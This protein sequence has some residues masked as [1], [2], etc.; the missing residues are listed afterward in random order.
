MPSELFGSLP[1]GTGALLSLLVFLSFG[2]IGAPLVV[3][4]AAT[5]AL[6][7]L[8]GASAA[9][10]IIIGV[11]LLFL[12]LP[13]LRQQLLT[14]SIVAALRKLNILPEISETEQIALQAGTTWVDK[15]LFSGKP[16]L[17]RII[18]KE[19]YV[20][21]SGEELAFVNGPVEELCRMVSDWQIWQDKDLPKAVWDYIKKERFLGMIIPK[22]YGGLGFSAMAHSEVIAKIGSRSMPAAV[23]VMVPNSLG[24]AELLTHYG[25]DK[26]KNHYLPRL[27]RGEEIPCFALT[28]PNAG[29]D[30]GSMVST[31]EV[32]KGDD[33]QI[34]VRLNWRKRYITLAAIST[35]IGLAVR[36]R[37]P[38]NLLGK[39]E[40]LGITCLLVPSTTKGV[41]LGKRHDPMGVPFFNCPTEGHDVVVSIDQIIGGA[42]GAGHGWKMLMECL[43]AG[44]SISL[45]AQSTGGSK[46]A[47]R[48]VSAYGTIRRQFGISIA[49]FEGIEEPLAR[50]YGFTY[51]MEAMRIFTAG[52]VDQGMKPSVVSAIAKYNATELSRKVINDA[53]DVLGGAAISRGPRNT[54]ANGYIATPIGITVEGANILTRSMIIFGQGAIRCHPYA[55]AEV[56]ALGEN[57]IKGFD[58]AFW[59]HVGFVIRNTCRAILLSVTRG[60]LAAV[61]G[62]PLAPYYRKLA[63]SSATFSVLADIAL[64]GLGGSLKFREKITGRFADILSWMYLATST[65]KRF[66]TEGR[67]K[68]HQIFAEWALQYCFARM[69]DAYDG[70]FANFDIPVLSKFFAGPVQ[71]WSRL[72]RL[73]QDPSDKLG[74][75]LVT[76]MDRPSQVRDD[77]TEG[78]FISKDLNDAIGRYENAFKL[79]CDSQEIFKKIVKASKEKKIS[80]GRPE[81]LV[82]EAIAAGV[83]TKEEASI[84][85]AAEIA[86]NDAIQ[87]DSYKLEDY[88]AGVAEAAPKNLTS[89][90]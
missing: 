55:F 81:K 69:Q 85:R 75:K 74:H 22:E 57:D 21:L 87:V 10:W 11:P 6:M 36:L 83:I 29:S 30:A 19:R 18:K 25:T 35:L 54:L 77:L 80:K 70:L 23:T 5:A 68:E 32:F 63:W 49:K 24:P 39:G 31:G 64:G 62:G 72:N 2:F 60:R 15:D 44:R 61:P 27:A 46:V 26:Q 51:L 65:M 41:V 53:M 45:P 52:A 56:T 76:A 13:P 86:R 33:G 17:A 37:D 42:D 3:W 73:G 1:G 67:R 34:Y 78:M 84:A 43:A 50:I 82:D 8:L 79:V 59:G 4:T 88:R 66:E 58:R 89:V 47:T 14:R 38:K 28:E 12:N 7:W 71:L 40:D 20:K 48:V 9:W 16:D 90:V